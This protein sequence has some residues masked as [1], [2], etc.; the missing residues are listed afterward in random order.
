V[1]LMDDFVAR[2][3]RAP[4]RIVFP[5]GTSE[6]ILSAAR[7]LADREVAVPMVVGRPDA[8]AGAAREAGVG[9][10]G[11][12][13]VD[14]TDGARLERYEAAYLAAHPL[15]PGLSKGVARRLVAK[16][17]MFGSM[18]VRLGEADAMIA[19]A[20]STSTAVIL[21][22]TDGI[23]LAKGVTAPSSFFLMMLPQVGDRREVLA[24]GRTGGAASSRED[25]PKAVSPAPV[26]Q[27]LRG[28]PMLFADCAVNVDPDAEALAAIAVASARSAAVLLPEEPRVA[29]LSFSTLGS[30]SHSL[31][32]KV[33][34]AAALARAA[35]P[36]IAIDGDLQADAA[37][38]PR[39][40]ARKAPD[41]PVAGR[42]NVLVFPSLEAGNICY[43]CV[44]YMAGAAAYGPILQGLRKPVSDLSRGATA[45]DTVATAAILS[46]MAGAGA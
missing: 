4:K 8:V 26:C 35:L 29:L 9:L 24:H 41:S 15:V 1:G 28:V 23:G 42:A 27:P 18:M 6:R 5:E 14:Q 39:V 16:R 21:Y 40:A 44:Q 17:L 43:K 37:I 30:A 32:D 38:V 13:V 25:P 2:A 7:V 33:R 20:E 36:D 31:V 12:E 45:Q 46:V 10:D 3:R 19:G 22:A 34:E 11:I